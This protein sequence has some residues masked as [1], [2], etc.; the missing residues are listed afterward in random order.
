MHQARREGE[1]ASPEGGG[2]AHQ[3]SA[4]GMKKKVQEAP[5][6][7]PH[8]LP[9]RWTEFARLRCASVCR[10]SA[11]WPRHLWELRISKS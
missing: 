5:T 7:R 8:P 4:G 1:G 6:A 2:P 10:L 9:A 3:G 11:T